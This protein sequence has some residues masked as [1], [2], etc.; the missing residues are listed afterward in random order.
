M[1]IYQ[2][3]QGRSASAVT[4]LDSIQATPGARAIRADHGPHEVFLGG[5]DR[6]WH[7]A[8]WYDGDRPDPADIT[9]F[10]R[11]IGLAS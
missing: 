8:P 6:H 10:R 5:A 4:S 7:R 2:V 1:P 11:R 3:T 9:T